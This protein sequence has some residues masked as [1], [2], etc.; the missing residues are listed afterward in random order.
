MRPYYSLALATLSLLVASAVPVTADPGFS[1]ETQRKEVT[2]KPTDK[3]V[4]VAFAFENKTKRNITISRYDSA[5]S[6]LSARVSDPE[7][8]LSYKPGEKGSIICDFELGSFSGTQEKTLMLWTT[9]DAK[10]A[11]S[12]ILT[13]SITVPVLFA[14]TPTTLFWDQNGDPSPKSFK[15][16]V[17][18]D[19]PIRILSHSGTHANFPFELKT[20]RDGWEYELVVSPKDLSSL[21]MGLIKLTTDSPIPRYRRQQAFVCTRRAVA[22]PQQ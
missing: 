21:G 7:G 5:C 22:Q 2:V 14:I 19:K 3:L 6:C 13:S 1:F 17:N 16:K 15:I 10:D 20:I 11:P 9:D 18:N 8:K 12:V 4:S